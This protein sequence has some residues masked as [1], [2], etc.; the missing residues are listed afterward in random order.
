M[1]PTPKTILEKSFPAY[2]SIFVVPLVAISVVMLVVTS[3][4][5][6]AGISVLEAIKN[7]VF[8]PYQPTYEEA[9]KWFE[10]GNGYLANLS[11]EEKEK[12]RVKKDL[13]LGL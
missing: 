8:P 4:M 13:P 6:S 10:D 1:S 9:K 3:I 5:L 11:E 2:I 12:L 7:L